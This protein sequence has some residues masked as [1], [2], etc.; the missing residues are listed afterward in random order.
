MFKVKN[1]KI[2][3]RHEHLHLSEKTGEPVYKG[4]GRFGVTC[5]IQQEGIEEDIY[6]GSVLIHKGGQ[7]DRVTGK[8]YA[9]RKAMIA[10]EGLDTDGHLAIIWYFPKRQRTEIWKAFWEW[11]ES[12]DKK[13]EINPV[14][15][16][17][18]VYD[19]YNFALPLKGMVEKIS[20]KDGAY[21]IGF[22]SN[23]HGY[24]NYMTKNHTYFFSQQCQIVKD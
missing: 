9:L 7:P 6:I 13:K 1:L 5:F 14:G 10:A 18:I 8:K 24:P 21:Q 20:E 2:S 15:K 11:V 19:R 17:V 23:Q 22:Y 3:F 16:T 4:T 12:W